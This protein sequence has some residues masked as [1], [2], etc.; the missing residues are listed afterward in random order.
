MAKNPSND[1]L[2]EKL[3]DAYRPKGDIDLE[4]RGWMELI[5]KKPIYWL[6]YENLMDA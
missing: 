4:I 6:L 3:A 2:R 5:E 1:Q